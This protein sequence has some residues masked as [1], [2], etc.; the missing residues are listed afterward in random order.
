MILLHT[1]T[2]GLYLGNACTDVT[3]RDRGVHGVVEN[4]C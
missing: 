4:R 1:C 2:A 3:I